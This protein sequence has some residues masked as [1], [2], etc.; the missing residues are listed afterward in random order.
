MS[1]FKRPHLG[2]QRFVSCSGSAAA[3]P[4]LSRSLRRIVHDVRTRIV[5]QGPS[6]GRGANTRHSDRLRGL[7]GVGLGIG[8]L[9]GIGMPLGIGMLLGIGVPLGVGVSPGMGIIGI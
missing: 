6:S 4:S 3:A 8:I 7:Q 1:W 2:A 5:D 9:L